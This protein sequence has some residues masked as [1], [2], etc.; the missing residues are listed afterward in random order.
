MF[1]DIHMDIY[2]YSIPLYIYVDTYIH[3]YGYKQFTQCVYIYIYPHIW[4]LEDALKPDHCPRDIL[5]GVFSDDAK[6][7]EFDQKFGCVFSRGN[8]GM[9]YPLVN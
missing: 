6:Q 9:G 4:P 3:T 2:I 1:I 5:G 7:S 8:G